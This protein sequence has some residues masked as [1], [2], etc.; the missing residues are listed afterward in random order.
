MI[1]VFSP[2]TEV[3]RVDQPVPDR[4][5]LQYSIDGLASVD[6][7]AVSFSAATEGSISALAERFSLNLPNHPLLIAGMQLETGVTVDY[8]GN[9]VATTGLG[10]GLVGSQDSAGSAEPTLTFWFDAPELV[11][12]AL[13]RIIHVADGFAVG[14]A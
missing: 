4:G 3:S 10:L 8:Q 7:V 14:R 2:L 5:P 11:P 9:Y 13:A 1:E 6:M 12:E